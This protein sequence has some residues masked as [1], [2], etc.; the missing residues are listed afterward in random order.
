[1]SYALYSAINLSRQ[2]TVNFKAA[3]QASNHL[4]SMIATTCLLITQST[5]AP[6]PDAVT[7]LEGVTTRPSRVNRAAF[8]KKVSERKDLLTIARIR[9]FS[10]YKDGW[11][12]PDSVRPTQETIDSAEKFARYLLSLGKIHLPYISAS[13]DGEINFYWKQENLTI[14]LGFVQEGFY[15]YYAELPTGE[16]IFMDDVALDDPLPQSVVTFITQFD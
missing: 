10:N 15:S 9:S 16:E 5:S 2:T 1:M 3:S 14:D 13:S 6:S 4:K 11:A 7:H 12:G 8:P